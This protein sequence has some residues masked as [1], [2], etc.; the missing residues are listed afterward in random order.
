[1]ATKSAALIDAQANFDATIFDTLDILDGP[2]GSGTVLVTYT[3]LSWVAASGGSGTIAVAGVPITKAADA[4]GS[5]SHAR[6]YSAAE[7][8][9]TVNDLTVTASGGGGQ[10]EIDNIVI[11]PAQ[12]VNL[13]SCA[14]QKPAAV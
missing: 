2:V 3:G 9:K 13:V 10:V 1:M 7:P 6:L 12:D 11:A 14:W 8:T 5:A 4:G